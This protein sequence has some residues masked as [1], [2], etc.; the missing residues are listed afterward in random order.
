MC[1]DVAHGF[2]KGTARVMHQHAVRCHLALFL[3]FLTGDLCTR[4]RKTWRK[5]KRESERNVRDYIRKRL[6]DL[7]AAGMGH[8]IT[9]CQ[10][11]RT[12]CWMD[13]RYWSLVCDTK[14]Q[15]NVSDTPSFIEAIKFDLIMKAVRIQNWWTHKELYIR[16]FPVQDSS[17]HI[18]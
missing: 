6:P 3:K 8:H 13:L 15:R 5:R 18:I 17:N 4:G 7:T 12:A 9:N 11:N 10:G 1:V 2:P 14:F 16:S